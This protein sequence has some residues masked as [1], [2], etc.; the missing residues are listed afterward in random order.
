MKIVVAS[1]NPQKIAA[2][3]EILQDYPHLK[4]AVIGTMEV[5]T[6]IPAQPISLDEIVE[7][8]VQRAKNSFVDCDYSIGLESGLMETPQA[9][10]GYMD[11]GVCAIYDGAQTHLGLSAGFEAPDPA[12]FRMVVV[13]GIELSEATKRVGLT[14]HEKIGNAEGIV[15]ILTK[16]RMNRKDQ[17]KQSLRTALIHLDP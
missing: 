13:E 10:S 1:K 5:T 17:V 9:K 3:T 7:G 16:G 12:I 14:T 6:T 8:A 4:D 15:G 2:V 11:I